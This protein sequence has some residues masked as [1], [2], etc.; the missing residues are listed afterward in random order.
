VL[1]ARIWLPEASYRTPEQVTGFFQEFA[2]RVR[3]LPGVRAAGLVRSLPLGATIGDWGLDLEGN[4]EAAGGR[5]KG[6]WQVAT[7]GA[8]EA[9]GER[10]VRG[11]VFDAR[12]TTDALQVAVINETMARSYWPGRDP[13]GQRIR[14]GRGRTDRPWV[15]IVGIVGDERHN[16]MTAAV[17]EKF[18]RPHSQFHRS[19]G[20]SVRGMTLVVRTDGDVSALAAPLRG[21]LRD[22]DRSLPLAGVRPM[23]DVVNDSVATP[24]AAGSVLGA[25]ALA[26]LALAAVGIYGVLA[27]LVGERTREIGVRMA[28]GATPAQILGLV[29]RQGLG[30]SGAGLLAGLAGAAAL[31]RTMGALL[32]DVR[33]LDPRTF[34]FVAALLGVVAAA[35]SYLPARRATRVNPIEALRNE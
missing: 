19:T 28:V 8:F 6:D 7:D 34:V 5:T 12:D 35:A 9:L 13:V 11:R 1:T 2:R 30:L 32:H 26:A 24:R 15:T 18:Y 29:L 23:T 10:L 20:N 25:F 17:K 21:V 4:A 3:T 33:P 14:L 27:Y 22:M 16:G 31:S